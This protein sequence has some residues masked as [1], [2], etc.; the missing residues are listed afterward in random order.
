MEQSLTLGI[1]NSLN[2]ACKARFSGD[3]AACCTSYISAIEGLTRIY[4]NK[5]IKGFEKG[6][7]GLDDALDFGDVLGCVHYLDN[8][9]LYPDIDSVA[10]NY[11]TMLMEIVSEIDKEPNEIKISRTK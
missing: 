5:V 10:L 2:N 7:E 3:S 1:I 6:F 9:S 8:K 11:N 4:A